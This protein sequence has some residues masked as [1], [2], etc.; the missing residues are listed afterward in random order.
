MAEH[1]AAKSKSKSKSGGHGHDAAAASK[2]S[3]GGKAKANNAAAAAPATSLDALFRPCGDVK[4]LRFGAQLVTRALTVRRAAPLEL[5]HL[6]RVADERQRE[7]PLAFAPTTTA[8]IPTNFAILAHHAWHTLTLGLGT[9]N[10]KAA[11]FVFESAAMKA[12]ADAAWP[13]VV[14]LGDAGRRLIRAAP[15]APEMARFKFRKG[16]V[17]F[18][19]YAARTAGARGFARADELRAVVEA[20]AKLK[21][22]LDHTAMLALPGQRS[23]DVAAAADAAAAAPVGV[24][25]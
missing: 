3:K 1:K 7:A 24:V 17:T 15:G 8:Y 18:Y 21:D 12:A 10:S 6:L 23:I 13:Q 19:V 25:H 5:P 11:V 22:F 20:V 16:C 4:G 9:R 14:P 2:K